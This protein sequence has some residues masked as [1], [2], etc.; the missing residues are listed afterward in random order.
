[1]GLAFEIGLDPAESSDFRQGSL[2]LEAD[3]TIT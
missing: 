2:L 3:F 1:M